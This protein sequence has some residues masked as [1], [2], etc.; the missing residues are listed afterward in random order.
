MILLG[1]SATPNSRNA[2]DIAIYDTK[3]SI[4][5][6]GLDIS[7]I[8]GSKN[9]RIFFG[10][11]SDNEI[12]EFTYKGQEGWFYGRCTKLCHTSQGITSFTPKLALSF[13]AGAKDSKFL[14]S[15]LL[16]AG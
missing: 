2:H 13:L 7:V 10:G 15:L 12:Y 3:M 8:E 4:N 16:V 11:R 5:T 1:I 6:K 9:G 14:Y